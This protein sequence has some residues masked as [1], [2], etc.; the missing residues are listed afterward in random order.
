MKKI[1]LITTNLLLIGIIVFVVFYYL[2]GKSED[3]LGIIDGDSLLSQ[4][5]STAKKG[6]QVV[7]ISGSSIVGYAISSN[8]KEVMYINN[9]GDLMVSDFIGRNMASKKK[10]SNDKIL[11]AL[12]ST[13]NPELILT[14]I[15]EGKLQKYHY[16]Y[17]EDKLTTL[18]GGIQD[19]AFSP[20]SGRIGYSFYDEQAYEGNISVSN[21]DGSQYVNIL[22]TRMP[23]IT[24]Y[25]PTEET[26]Y[27]HKTPTG[28]QK[29]DLFSLDIESEKIE[30]ILKD[31]ENLEISW[32]PNGKHIVYSEIKLNTPKLFYKN[33]SNDEER[34][35]DLE[36]SADKCVWSSDNVN[37]FCYRFNQFYKI[38][39]VDG[40]K[41]DLYK[42]KVS[43]EI[44]DLKITPSGE[45]LLFFNEENGQ[46]HN[47]ILR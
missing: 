8:G 46:L 10:L 32:S 15:E 29:V 31:K 13:K 30:N 1:L 21:P 44:S 34:E 24:I 37:V 3:G 43:T 40:E 23:D 5:A 39:T 25:W 35:L 19:I 6:S 45:N 38:N 22:Q 27:F 2:K 11:D 20:E 14:T 33:L 12:W 16:D 41:A 26:I 9:N 4:F 28:E 36:T 42:F 47:L 7:Q 17:S 18:H